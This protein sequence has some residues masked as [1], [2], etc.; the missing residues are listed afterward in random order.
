METERR[1]ILA[2][3]RRKSYPAIGAAHIWDRLLGDG[4]RSLVLEVNK[5]W[6][7]SCWDVVQVTHMN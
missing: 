5:G 4:V 7:L 2:K 1:H 3:Y 6:V